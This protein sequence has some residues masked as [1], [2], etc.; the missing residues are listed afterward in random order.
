[1]HF[2]I[3]KNY[4]G[5]QMKKRRFALL[6]FFFFPYALMAVPIYWIGT[7]SDVLNPLNWNPSTVPSS[8]DLA[9]FDVTGASHFPE[10]N[11]GVF[12]VSGI[13]FS[14]PTSQ[15][16]FTGNFS[17]AT[18]FYGTGVTN[19]TSLIE[20]IDVM[21]IS[22]INFFNDSSADT[23]A[24]GRM[25]YNI[26]TSSAVSFGDTSG[27]SNA[28]FNVQSSLFFITNAE[29]ESALINLDGLLQFSGSSRAGSSSPGFQTTINATSVGDIQFTDTSDP[30][31]AIINLHDASQLN[32]ITSGTV[33]QGGPIV[34]M[35]DS[36][37]TTVFNSTTV[38]SLNSPSTTTTLTLGG[39]NLTLREAPGVHDVFAGA[40]VGTTGHLI[41]SAVDTTGSFR[42]TSPQNPANTWIADVLVGSLIGNTSNLNRTITT[43]PQGTVVF[44][45][46]SD[47][48]FNQSITGNGTLRKI[49]P[50]NLSVTSNNSTFAGVTD[51]LNGALVLDGQLGGLINVYDTLLGTGIANGT[52]NVRSGGTVSPGN[53]NIS[54]LQVGDYIHH[55][56]ATYHVDLNGNG[57]SDLIH[58]VPGAGALGTA[59]ILGGTVDAHSPNGNFLIDVPYTIVT[60][61][62]GRSGQ[63]DGVTN[64]INQFLDPRLVYDPTHVYLILGTDFEAF[65]QTDNQEEV[66]EQIDSI[67]NPSEALQDFLQTLLT[68]SP[69]ELRDALDQLSGVQF[70]SIFSTFQ[71]ANER[72]I[73]GLNL[74]VRFS[75][76]ECENVCDCYEIWGDIQYGRSYANGNDNA[77]GYKAQNINAFIATQMKVNPC[78]RWGAA[79]YYENDIL[80]YNL[81][82]KSRTNTVL[83]TIFGVYEGANY[84][85]LT[86]LIGGY[87]HYNYRR[88]LNFGDIDLLT[89]SHPRAYNATLY[90]E[91]GADF[92]CDCLA[93]QP[94]A[95]LEGG[96]YNLNEVKENG[97][98]PI[99]LKVKNQTYRTLDSFLGLR[100][101][102]TLSCGLEVIVEAAWQH[103]FNND[104]NKIKL[105]F[106]EF[107]DSFTVKGPKQDKDG[108]E[109]SI[110]CA[111]NACENMKI[112]GEANGVKWNNY[113][114]YSFGLGLDINW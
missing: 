106:Q 68:L 65:A 15:Y 99:G 54:T 6:P 60:A 44:D 9:I 92:C 43:A 25:V 88:H 42:L 94:F 28:T 59:N 71:R 97:G 89:R 20:T 90:G 80:R 83:G 87:S 23:S 76:C 46:Q 34:T 13:L 113:Y 50:A 26:G 108:V 63:Y 75:F 102:G 17:S 11:G 107:G 14:D 1:M 84:Y 41:L 47:G 12:S 8:I 3:L 5:F 16:V 95:G 55:Q 72:L 45:Q 101:K 78:S 19:S 21:N 93:F 61:D 105:R 36:S 53:H 24:S 52:V 49:G 64:N 32:F 48:I 37:N 56:N 40:I 38:G 85:V 33:T 31:N 77:K 10:N 112:F 104:G 27:A 51:I 22:V 4:L 73:H 110:V 66:A 100:A 86:D 109:A 79:I 62:G 70:S 69:S 67:E 114:N 57:A 98:D 96:Y 2:K 74:P 58:A 7:T 39:Q 29:S 30:S 18:D 35:F 91:F 103:R 111:V 81:N 82:G